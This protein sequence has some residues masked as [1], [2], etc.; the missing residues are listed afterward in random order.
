MQTT[1]PIDLSL[2]ISPDPVAPGG[3]LVGMVTVTNNTA[4]PL[5]G[6]V[7]TLRM[8]P[9]LNTFAAATISGGALCNA[10][11]GLGNCDPPELI[12]WNVGMLNGSGQSTFTLPPSVRMATLAGTTI[13]FD[14][15][16]IT[17]DKANASARRIVQVQ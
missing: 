16:A 7:V 11:G 1:S 6:V 12:V 15:T 5:T 2:Q 10:F 8:P 4:F 14:A 3:A 13:Q 17:G 9:E